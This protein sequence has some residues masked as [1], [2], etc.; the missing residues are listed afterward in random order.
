MIFTGLLVPFVPSVDRLPLCLSGFEQFLWY[1]AMIFLCFRW[2]GTWDSDYR[3][4]FVPVYLAML[5]RWAQACKF[6]ENDI[7]LST[8]LAALLTHQLP[9]Y[10][11]DSHDAP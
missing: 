7:L 4:I 5:V 8:Y 1:L 3:Q 10:P 6:F 9:S 11:F 2:D